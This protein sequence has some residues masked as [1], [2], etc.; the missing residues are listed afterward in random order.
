MKKKKKK[1]KKKEEE[2]EENDV[3]SGSVGGMAMGQ[4]FTVGK[5]SSY[6]TMFGTDNLLSCGRVDGR[7]M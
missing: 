5:L 2:E 7:E 4:Q 6:V 3:F 1:K